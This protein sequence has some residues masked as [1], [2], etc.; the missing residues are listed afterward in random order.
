[1]HVAKNRWGKNG[2]AVRRAYRPKAYCQ[3]P[4]GRVFQ[5]K[6]ASFTTG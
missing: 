2:H 3:T 1:M 5:D 4:H 6:N